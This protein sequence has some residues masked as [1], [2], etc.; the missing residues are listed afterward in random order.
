MIN[1]ISFSQ[2]QEFIDSVDCSSFYG[3][4]SETVDSLMLTI[5]PS[6]SLKYQ[7]LSPYDTSQDDPPDIKL[8]FV[9]TLLEALRSLLELNIP[10]VSYYGISSYYVTVHA[11]SHNQ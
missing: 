6:G 2:M 10:I 4:V 3:L 5:L 8:F 1:V 7:S 9:N 11:C